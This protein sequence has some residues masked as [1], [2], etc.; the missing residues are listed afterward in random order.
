MWT[1]R[2]HQEVVIAPTL[3][4]RLLIALLV[5]VSTVGAIDAV[6][7][8]SFDHAVMHGAVLLTAFVLLARSPRGRPLVPVRADLYRWLDRYAAEGGED[9]ER[10][11]DRAVSSY[12]DG[13]DVFADQPAEGTTRP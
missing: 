12:R 13:F 8:R 5:V 3:A 2:A 7:S 6:A 10:V 1:H 4:H 9:V 11:L